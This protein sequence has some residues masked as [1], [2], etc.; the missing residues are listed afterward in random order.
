MI[1][2]VH[3]IL[4]ALIFLA[5][6]VLSR[7]PDIVKLEVRGTGDNLAGDFKAPPAYA[8]LIRKGHHKQRDALSS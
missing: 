4:H 7:H 8:G 1:E 6:E 5:D 2:V 3:D